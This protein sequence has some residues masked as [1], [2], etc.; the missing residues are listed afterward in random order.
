MEYEEIKTAAVG[1]V[2]GKDRKTASHFQK[3][4]GNMERVGAF[5]RVSGSFGAHRRQLIGHQHSGFAKDHPWLL[6]LHLQR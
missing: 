5:V 1:G 6:L 2:G 4:S 3:I